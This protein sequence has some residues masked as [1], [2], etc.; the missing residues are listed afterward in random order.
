MA[1]IQKNPLE[2]SDFKN[3]AI[4]FTDIT[5]E[6]FKP[7]LERAIQ[8]AKTKIATIKSSTDTATFANTVLALET[9]S[10]GVDLVSA[11]FYNLLHA[12]TNEQLQKLAPEIGPIL[13]EFGSDL[14]LDPAL[15]ARIEQV[16]HQR[17]ELSPEQK[18]LVEKYYENFKRNGA[19]LSEDKKAE[20]REIDKQLSQ[21]GPQFSE[22]VLR[23][24]NQFILLLT[25][26]EEVDGLPEISLQAA[27]QL[28]TERGHQEGWAFTLHAPS[29]LPFMQFGTH[30]PSREKL[31]RAYNTRAYKDDFDNQK[32]IL[33]ILE[34]RE[35]RAQLLGY[36][37]HAEFTLEL[38]MAETPERVFDFIHKLLTPSLKMAQTEVEQIANYAQSQG[39]PMPLQA[40]D[41]TFWS[42]R[43]KEHLF[44]FNAEELRPYFS[45]DKVVAGAFEHARLLYGLEFQEAPDYPVYHPDVKVYEVHDAETDQFIGLFYTDFYPRE[46][47][48]GGAWMTNYYE[49]GLYN[50]QVH[51]PHVAICCNFTKPTAT[52]P[53]LL[54]YDEVQTLFHEFGHSLHSLLSKCEYRSLSGTNVYWDFVELPSQIMEN[55]TLEKEALDLFAEHY[56]TAEKLPAELAEKLKKSG[57]YLA[58]YMSLRQLSFALLDMQYHTTPAQD[59][60]NPAE[61]EDK[62]LAPLR[63]LPAVDG[64]N[65]SC[66]FSHIFA[67]G[68]S[69]GYYS[70]KWAEVLDADAFELFLEKGLFNKNVAQKFK[71]HILS[72]GGTQHPMELYK[73]FRGREP[74][75]NALLRR[76]G[77]MVR[78]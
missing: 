1:Q 19:L 6:L 35:R 52:K 5:P 7:Q 60:R 18:K 26:P 37:N 65:V 62:I 22:N 55:W 76:D 66:A 70:Y 38:R 12:H 40:W 46:S 4:R 47:K 72:R 28:A 25:K 39:A 74:D 77:L 61:Y 69:A 16:Y 78:S 24:T 49:Q 13:A 43:Y 58:G 45:L 50:D 54:T 68:Y 59:V 32:S 42:E 9:C 15:F 17:A 23:A 27:K 75:P 33:K 41:F 31:Y 71:E 10:E 8:Q 57:K 64:I 21:L 29:Y 53:S 20:L 11:I 2:F 30:R 44:K 51:R 3:H 56:Q 63:V 48:N 67:G 36:K 34:L 73:N 14:T